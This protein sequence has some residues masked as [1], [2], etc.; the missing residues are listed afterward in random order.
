M[1]MTEWYLVYSDYDG[2]TYRVVRPLPNARSWVD[3]NGI[4]TAAYKDDKVMPISDPTEWKSACNDI[5]LSDMVMDWP[6]SPQQKI[7]PVSQQVEAADKGYT[8]FHAYDR[9]GWYIGPI[10]A[11]YARNALEGAHD[12]Y[13]G[14]NVWFVSSAP[15]KAIRP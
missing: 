10:D 2:P 1:L 12:M 4:H 11:S 6:Y 8:R 14:L 7:E 9:N 13:R 3:Q 15:I 5:V